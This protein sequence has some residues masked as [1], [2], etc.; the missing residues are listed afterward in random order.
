MG[1]PLGSVKTWLRRGLQQL[2]QCI[3][4]VAGERNAASRA[5]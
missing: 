3:E 5:I 2:K 4:S 1:S